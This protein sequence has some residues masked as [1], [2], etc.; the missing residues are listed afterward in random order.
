LFPHKTR[1]WLPHTNRSKL[2]ECSYESV[3][4]NNQQRYHFRNLLTFFGS[5]DEGLIADPVG[6]TM[7]PVQRE[8]IRLAQIFKA[9]MITEMEL[10]QRVIERT[11]IEDDRERNLQEE[12]EAR[13][14]IRPRVLEY[15]RRLQHH[16]FEASEKLSEAVE[17]AYSVLVP[18]LRD[19]S[20]SRAAA[21][22]EQTLSN[23]ERT[24]AEAFPEAAVKQLE[25]KERAE[26]HSRLSEA[27]TDLPNRIATI[28]FGLAVV[29]ESS[30]PSEHLLQ[31]ADRVEQRLRS[32]SKL[33]SE[34][35]RYR[36]GAEKGNQELANFALQIGEAAGELAVAA[37][38]LD[39]MFA[40]REAY[41]TGIEDL[42]DKLVQAAD[43]H[44][45]NMEL[46]GT[47]YQSLEREYA[48]LPEGE[49][50]D[51]L[52]EATS[53]IVDAARG[54]H[55]AE[56][57][58]D[59]AKFFLARTRRS[60]EQRKLLD[61]L[62]EEY[63]QK[64]I[65]LL[66]G[67]R[68]QIAS[69]DNYLKRLSIALEDDFKVQFYDPAFVR[70][71]R[72]ARE[73]DVSLSQVERT[74]ILTNNRALAKVTPAA[75]M[76]FDLPKRNIAIVEALDGA[77][78]LA[79]DYGALLQD[80][81]FLAA[82]QLMGGGV[83]NGKV[84]NVVPGL[85]TS[86]DEQQMGF[87][88]MPTS[89]SGSA[90]Q[91]LVPDPSVF[92]FETGTGYE[93]RP[94]IQPDGHSIIYDFLYMYT[95]NVREPIQADEKHL[96][97][98]RRHFINTQVQTSSFEMRELSRYQVSLKVKRTA[99]G[100]PLLQD[101]PVAGL[102]FRPLPS[103]E[104]SIQQNIILAYSAV[105]PT[106]FDLMGLRWA[107]SVVDLNHVSVRDSEHVV[108]G[109]NMAVTDSIFD[110]ST[111]TVDDILGIKVDTPDHHRPDLYH[112]QRQPSPYHP[113]GYTHPGRQPNDD[114]TGDGFEARDAR[115]I[116]MRQPPYDRRFRHPI[117]Y[118][119]IP[120]ELPDEV[121]RGVPG[122]DEDPV[123]ESQDGTEDAATSPLPVFPGDIAERDSH[124]P[125]RLRVLPTDEETLERT[126][127]SVRQ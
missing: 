42:F 62:I 85:P 52:R 91:S 107:P 16:R 89:P 98:V 110:I 27:Y 47:L 40:E 18:I 64:H 66:E 56:Q 105:Y 49:K 22:A 39:R 7:S 125:V 45:I 87:T 50:Y 102:L 43:I 57:K 19:L 81:T 73:W 3:A 108:R 117:R 74:S 61:F 17:N 14:S 1:A 4:L 36:I 72:A 104:S 94:V 2:E 59:N 96:G 35:Q 113:G 6:N 60:L 71:R 37:A 54:V 124:M 79:Q 53:S 28:R 97:R 41:W 51:K 44:Q 30:S 10:K 114:P 31:E 122:E 9:R 24:Y 70:I 13:N 48:N 34:D 21:A 46:V 106:L 5:L 103:A 118:E 86:T 111:R 55:L 23:A 93:I 67:T 109:R 69:V 26:L 84:Q 92:K 83:N 38:R 76:E 88:K 33:L 126:H 116:E 15:S 75:T 121:V 12:E 58:Y 115:P 25:D 78:A 100:V 20:I 127:D 80:P 119:S 77:K 90:L 101:I 99:Q 11:M 82:Y 63:E 95:T 120:Y 112:R 68:A 123:V 8:F 32:A 29:R 65:D